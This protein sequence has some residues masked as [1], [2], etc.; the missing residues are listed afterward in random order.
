L[1]SVATLA[2]T[3]AFALVVGLGWGHWL[4]AD[5]AIVFFILWAV[6]GFGVT[7]GLHRLLTHRSFKTYRWLRYLWAW[8]GAM[9]LEGPLIQWVATHRKHHNFS[10]HDGDPHS[11]HG[12]GEGFVGALKGL[13]HA[14]IGWLLN[15]DDAAPA[16]RYAPDLLEDPGM[17]FISDHYLLWVL[18]S[19]AVVP[20]LLGL[21]IGGVGA[22]PGAILWGGIMRVFWLHHVTYSI[23][24]V[25][26]FYGRSRFATKDGSRNVFWLA[27]FTFGESWH[28]NHHA[29]PT[30]AFHGLRWYEFDPSAIIIKGMR[31]T[32]LAWDVI[33]PTS[34]RQLAKLQ[35]Q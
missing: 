34:Q 7:I 9:S 2:P 13:W 18:L 24:S 21:A 8:A 12:H 31:L 14:H 27:P 25:C 30:S 4:N 5:D 19:L 32:H 29:F 33:S 10:D 28:N 26:H 20:G 23:N 35:T 3:I 16:E 15:L 17:R 22:I 1:N 11:P 6:S